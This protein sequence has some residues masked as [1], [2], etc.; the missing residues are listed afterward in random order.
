ML[1]GEGSDELFAGYGRYRFYL[2]NEKLAGPYGMLPAALRR[3]IR[4]FVGTSPL[5]KAGLRR[6][7]QHTFL[8]RELGFESL[9]IDN[10]HAAFSP[11]EQAYLLRSAELGGGP[12]YDSFQQY[13]RATEGKP[14][15]SRL[16][17]SDM[18]TYL[19]ELLMKQD[20]MSMSTSIE[21]RVPFLDHSFVEFAAG[22]PDHMKLRKGVGKYMFK[23][24]AED[25]IPHDIIYRPKMGFPTPL[26]RWLREEYATPVFAVLRKKDG[27]LAELIDREM[28]DALIEGQSSGAIDAT[29]RL[30]RLL[31][32]Q[33]WGET[34]LKGRRRLD[35][36]ELV[37]EAS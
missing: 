8:G 37:S 35:W 36:D 19:V 28:L 5:L 7:L 21:S 24:V 12:A 31:N 15:L 13:W 34:F 32:L 1:T 11:R 27:V 25:L 18:K 29:D 33:I 4:R 16:L 10:F 30:W 2:L 3:G 23:K 20:Q 6:K 22:A 17:Y 9:Y 14:T 26:R